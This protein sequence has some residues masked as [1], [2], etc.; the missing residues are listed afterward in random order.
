MSGVA[1][2]TA[3]ELYRDCLRLVRHVAPG[4]SP[5]AMALRRT[6]RMQFK[7]N[8]S[9]ED[10]KK[11]DSLK[12]DAVRALSNYMVYQSAQKDSRLQKAMELKDIFPKKENGDNTDNQ[13]S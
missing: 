3:L 12:S 8:A 2:R 5:K 10:P 4:E 9:E 6:V 11:I 13:N 1:N 7:R